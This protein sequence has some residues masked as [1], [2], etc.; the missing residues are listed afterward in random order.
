MLE[1]RQLS[2]ADRLVGVDCRLRTGAVTAIV[3]PNGA[4]KSTLLGAMAGL[5]SCTSG[6]VLLDGGALAA[7]AA[8]TRARTIGYLPQSGDVAWNIS[9]ETLVALGRLPHG[10]ARE[11]DARIVADTLSALD[12][13]ALAGRPVGQLSGGERARALLARVIAGEPRWILAD[14]PLAALDLGHQ[15]A[16]LARL[17]ALATSGVG[18][19]LVLHDLALVMNCAD[20]VL[21]LSQGRAVAE[22]PPET[23]LTSALIRSV[24][25]VDA[26]WLGAPGCRALALRPVDQ[27]NR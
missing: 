15:Q 14:E 5:V 16:L 12:L 3:G 27:G 23:T 26:T 13:T 11:E 2:V 10:G 25:G 8:R 1:A 22:G 18:V 6:T 19:V 9:V 20:H 4:G 24:W 21:V 7:M 17:R